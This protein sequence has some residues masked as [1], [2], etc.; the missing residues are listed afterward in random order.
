VKAMA[1]RQYYIDWLR[2]GAMFFLVFYHTGRLF[3]LEPWHIKS[4]ESSFA[5]HVFNRTLDVWQMPLFFLLAGASVWFSMGK[6]SPREFAKERFLRL[7]VPL[8]FGSLIIVPPQ[9]YFERILDGDF[10]GSFLAWYPNTFH[11]I[12]QNGSAEGNFHWSHLWFLAYLFF[13]SLILLPLFWHLRR[14]DKSS[15]ISRIAGFL[16][17]PGA[18]FLPAIPLVIYNITLRPIYGYG[19]HSLISDWANFLFYITIFFCGFLMVANSQITQVIHKNRF[20]ALFAAIICTVVLYLLETGILVLPQTI[21]G[22]DWIILLTLY[23]I[24]SWLCL[25]AIMGIGRQL[26]NFTNRVLRYASGAVLPVY[27]LHQTVI[28]ALGFYVIQ[29]HTAIVVKYFFVAIATLLSSLGIYEIV[30]RTSVTRFLFGI[31]TRKRLAPVQMPATS[32]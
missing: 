8:V 5:I 22:K 20:T 3:D 15:V 23:A 24:D 21:A 14:E 32:P 12:Y 18:I 1:D 19:N 6:R 28:I 26:L 2:A 31:K 27:I 16:A 7:F 9:V 13:F 17:R 29:W 25:L 30:R 10:T 11:G 4:L